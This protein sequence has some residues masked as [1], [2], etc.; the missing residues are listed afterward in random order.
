[1]IHVITYATHSSGNFNNL[2]NNK[3]GIK[4]KVLGWGEKWKG[5]KNK[6]MVIYNYIQ[7][8]NDNDVVISLDGFDV[9]IKGDLKKVKKIFKNNKYKVLFSKEF[10]WSPEIISKYTHRKVFPTT[11]VNGVVINAGLYMGYVK[12]LKIILKDILKDKGNDDQRILNL[13]CSKY[14]FISIDN[15]NKIFQNVNSE[16][17]IKKSK[18]IFVQVPFNPS[19]QRYFRAIGEY[20]PYFKYEIISIIIFIIFI[21]LFIKYYNLIKYKI[22]PTKNKNKNKKLGIFF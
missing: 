2:I 18:A 10:V 17:E 15:D 3:Y 4:I 19:V 9:W 21:Y 8:L 14:D 20:S 22:F 6:I 13:N 1:M 7:N 11:C 12:Y 5:F 16:N